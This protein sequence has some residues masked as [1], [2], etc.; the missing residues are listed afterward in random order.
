MRKDQTKKALQ[1]NSSIEK[2]EWEYLEY[3]ALKNPVE[4][5]LA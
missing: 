2:E 3:G 4:H 1:K 5:E